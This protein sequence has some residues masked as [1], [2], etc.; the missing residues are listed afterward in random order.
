MPRLFK[1]IMA[2]T[3]V[4]APIV[5][6]VKVD[7]TQD[8]A[9]LRRYLKG[10]PV[11]VNGEVIQKSRV[12][13]DN[14]I[15]GQIHCI[16]AVVNG[17]MKKSYEKR[18]RKPKHAAMGLQYT[19]EWVEQVK[20]ELENSPVNTTKNYLTAIEN[21]FNANGHPLKIIKPKP[22]DTSDTKEYECLSREDVMAIIRQTGNNIRDKA[23]LYCLWGSAI[24]AKEL[25]N[26]HYTDFI[27]DEKG[28]GKILVRHGSIKGKATRTVPL[29]PDTTQILTAWMN[30]RKI[31]NL[32]TE[33]YPALFLS[34]SDGAGIGYDGVYRVM[35]YY[36]NK[37]GYKSIH[38]HDLRHARISHL[39]NVAQ[40]PV[41]PAVVMKIAGHKDLKTTLGYC[42][43]S[44]DNIDAA[45]YGLNK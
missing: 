25:V 2:Q 23:L 4:S 20:A 11:R 44:Q 40:P 34:V 41:Q 22:I 32:S 7:I 6:N 16:E 8:I 45:I 21:L 38:P 27:V 36:A 24:R 26:L 33:V 37:A 14:T 15:E 9:N 13:T 12:C 29:E 1:P 17:G 18:G 39:L 3:V 35:R 10:N 30:W 5:T 31:N 43:T 28:N 42:H 19:D